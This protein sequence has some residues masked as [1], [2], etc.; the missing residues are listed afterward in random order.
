M[1]GL[2]DQIRVR[3]APSPT[4]YLHIGGARTALFNWLFAARNG[5]VFVLR[6][7]DTDADRAREE[8]VG[9]ILDSLRWLGLTWQ[10]GPDVGGPYGPYVQ[11]QRLDLYRR[12]AER[13]IQEGKAYPCYCTVEE[14]EAAR[15]Q[16]RREGRTYRYPGTCRHLTEEERRRLEAQGRPRAVRLVGPGPGETVVPDLIHGEVRFPNDEFDDFVIMKSDG[17][18]V[19]NFAVA[20]DDHH[21]GITHVIRGE[22]HLSN[23]PRQLLVYRALGYEPPAFAHVPMVLAPDRSKLSKRH[24][25]VA[26][27]EFR[28]KG[29]L[30]E[31]ILNY[32]ALLGWSPGD[33]REV[34]T[35]EEMVE[36]FS[37]E[38][39]SKTAAIY[40]VEKMTWLNG[41]HLRRADLD[42]VF[43]LVRPRLEA[44]GFL[45]RDA[46]P[47]EL[48]HARAVVA[49][50]RDRVRT[51]E[52]IV[53]ASAYFFADFEDYDPEGVRKRFEKPGV[54]E[55]LAEA[56]RRLEAVEPFTAES[57]EHAFRAL[58]QEKGISGGALFHPVRL[59]LTG[60]TMGPGLFDVIALLGRRRCLE[61]LDRAVRFIKEKLPHVQAA[62]AAGGDAGTEGGAGA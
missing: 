41:Q 38:R 42:R 6:I 3:F 13:L 23:T 1:Q 49:A 7:E 36:A 8:T 31:A 5:G 55:L 46:G 14:I 21:M 33:D 50:V 61:R 12:E 19:Y 45:P 48:A 11:S 26:V 27:E 47:E 24:G 32:T 43:A 34:L 56:R 57:T 35:L 22:E 52:E 53:D 10:E 25:A 58:C 60:R 40:D 30:P 15:E 29:F 54:A 62:A 51:L 44:R 20:V 59:A 39:I 37:L 4:G 28:E 17:T 2:P 9:P 18:P 16:A